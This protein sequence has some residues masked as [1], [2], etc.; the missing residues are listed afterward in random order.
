MSF[1]AGAQFQPRSPPPS[2]DQVEAC[3]VTI[4]ASFRGYRVR[5]T[6]LVPG[7]IP[8]PLSLPAQVSAAGGVAEWNGQLPETLSLWSA[9][10]KMCKAISVEDALADL[11]GIMNLG[12]NIWAYSYMRVLYQKSM[13]IFYG[14]L[15]QEPEMLMP[16]V[17]TP[18]VG[19]ACQKFGIMPFYSR[20]CYVS[21]S[22]RGNIKNV[23]TEYAEAELVKN[24]DGTY[25]CDC[26]VFSD[27]GRILGL[28]DLGAWGMGI[29]IGKL[30]LYTTCAGVDPTRTVPVI[31]D[32]GIYDKNGNTA[33]ID[34]RDHPRY[35]G[36]K[37][38]R[39]VHKSE[40]G[41]VVNSAYYGEA[42]M[43]QEFMEAATQ[44]FG[45]NV[46]LQFEDFNSND[47]FPLLDTFRTQFVSYNDD[48]QGTAAVTCAGILGALKIKY[49][50]CNDL[51]GR[52]ARERILF[53]GSGS[54]NIGAAALLHF[55][56]GV[57]KS[58]LFMTNSRGLMWQ[59]PDGTDGTYR[60]DEQK[61]F[62]VLGQP[63][64]PHKTLEDIISLVTPTCL[65]G[66]TGR[67]PGAFDKTVIETMLAVNQHDEH[68][69]ERPVV[70]ALSNPRTQAEC[71]SEEAYGFSNGEVIFGSGTK[72]PAVT[73]KGVEHKPGMV[74]NVYIFPG[75]SFGI[76]QCAA[77]SIPDSVF[78][79]AAEAVANSLTPQDIA[80]DL[81]LIH[82]S[83]PTRLL[84][85]SY[86]VFCLKKK[87]K[88]QQ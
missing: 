28:G 31:L 59:S 7:K 2:A 8:R 71:T 76:S 48:I 41:T 46:I 34:I 84:S 21:V 13:D 83:E 9:T 27:G 56:G 87:K 63:D 62:A 37:Q 68:D 15:M 14:C 38:D 73:V 44:V 20:G 61:E 47:A 16:V 17:Y 55:E 81:S 54:A 11:R 24:P 52:L 23:L 66:A 10:D 42:N 26:I 80:E 25:G 74:N 78:L 53:H 40:S 1:V 77:A 65:V 12:H 4:Q 5:K 75:L 22:Q 85:I 82:I 72:F 67:T 33:K 50:Q 60:N 64:A 58:Q 29:P 49:P 19:E 36:L 30:D 32:A 35:T 51:V 18:T 43:V 88:K 70:F 6:P 86:A 3:A 69:V 45:P 79:R 57:P 39:V